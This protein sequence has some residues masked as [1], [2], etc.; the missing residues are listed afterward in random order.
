M[1]DGQGVRGGGGGGGGSAFIETEEF[2]GWV[3]FYDSGGDRIGT[4]ELKTAYGCLLRAPVSRVV[5]EI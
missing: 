1:L 3:G 2:V 5:Y 4:S